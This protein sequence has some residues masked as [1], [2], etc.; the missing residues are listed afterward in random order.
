[1]LFAQEAWCRRQRRL[2]RTGSNSNDVGAGGSGVG[3]C[4]SALLQD[5]AAVDVH[6]GWLCKQAC[7][8]GVIF[9]FGDWLWYIGLGHTSVSGGLIIGSLHPT[10]CRQNLVASGSLHPVFLN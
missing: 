3:W 7:W 8:L 1:M 4:E 9:S 6:F 5:L 10:F 2:Q